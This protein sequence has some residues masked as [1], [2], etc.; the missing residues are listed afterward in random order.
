MSAVAKVADYFLRL[1][2]KNRASEVPSTSGVAKCVKKLKTKG[3]SY[4]DDA[5][6]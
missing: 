5:N 2:G 1:C 4:E 3:A 6:Q